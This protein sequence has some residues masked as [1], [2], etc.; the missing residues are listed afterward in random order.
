MI[1]VLLIG[2]MLGMFGM[3]KYGVISDH[4]DSMKQE[5]DDYDQ[6]LRRLK[7]QRGRFENEVDSLKDTVGALKTEADAIE[8]NV[9]AFSGLMEDLKEIY[10]GKEDE[11]SILNDTHKIFHDTKVFLLENERAHLLAAF[12]EKLGRDDNRMGKSEYEKF[13]VR[14]SPQQRA[15]FEEQGPFEVLADDNGKI[16]VVKFQDIVERVLVDVDELLRV[17]FERFS[18]DHGHHGV[19]R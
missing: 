17:E 3:F 1:G 8:E 11:Q 5:N 14:L 10:E 15:K 13:K 2:S 9:A 6:E 4:I 16:D 12:Y 19:R 7:H 18:V